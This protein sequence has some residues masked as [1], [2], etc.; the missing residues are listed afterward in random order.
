MASQDGRIRRFFYT[1]GVWDYGS[2]DTVIDESAPLDPLPG[3][4]W[5]VA[6]HDVAFDL[7][8][9]D[10]RATVFQPGIVYGES[11]GLLAAMFAAAR[12]T[13]VVSVAE[14]GT[15]RWPMVHRVDVADA[16][17]RALERGPAGARLMLARRARLD[18]AAHL[19]RRRGG[20]PVRRVAVGESLHRRVN[21]LSPR[22]RVDQPS[23]GNSRRST[24]RYPSA[25]SAP[26]A[27]PNTTSLG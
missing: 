19:V 22:Y 18:A 15:Q 24:V 14:G 16:Y 20:R 17:A 27:P 10:V 9:D 1:S 5:R 21:G 11:R 7:A 4:G 6:H 8:A 23:A 25:S 2:S 26:A 12:E 13:G 3:R